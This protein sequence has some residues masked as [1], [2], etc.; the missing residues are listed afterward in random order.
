[1]HARNPI[2]AIHD[3]AD[4]CTHV[5]DVRT[6]PR[7]LAI[8]HILVTVNGAVVRRQHERTSR[9]LRPYRETR[10]GL[11]SQRMAQTTL[12]NCRVVNF[13]LDHLSLL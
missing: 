3:R 12:L 1:M 8:H 5:R 7:C 10:K 13:I 6:K 2:N 4:A 11:P 9:F